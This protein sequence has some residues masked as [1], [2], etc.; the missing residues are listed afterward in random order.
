MQRYVEQLIDD[1]EEA[2]ANPPAKPFI[3]PPLHMEE[4]EEISELALVPFKPIATWTGIS[5]EVF[6]H[7]FRLTDPQVA[8]LLEAMF[9]LLESIK[10]E[11]VD[12]PEEIPPEMLY[13]ILTEYW[14]DKV[15]YLPSS[16]MD[17]EICT[18][19]QQT[20][21][22]GEFCDCGD[23]FDFSDDDF[24]VIHLNDSDELDILPF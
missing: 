19:N 17:W 22:Y 14:D 21:P 4:D 6:P 11:L 16:G 1:L 7:S 12:I 20:C 8:L 5:P 3:E 18:G 10:V 13:D 15:Q 9:K 2:A 24:P 23:H